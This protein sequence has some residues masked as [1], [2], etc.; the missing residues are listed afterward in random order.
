VDDFRTLNRCLD[1]AIA[2][3]V[4]EFARE[5]DVARDDGSQELRTLTSTAI[6][7]FEVLQTGSVGIAGRTG[8]LV[9]RSLLA[10]RALVG[11]PAP[12]I[13][14]PALRSAPVRRD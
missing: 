13:A 8:I 5:Q 2:E 3:A 1:D 10:I 14:D 12:Q 7:A 4:T 9:H 6:A 11:R